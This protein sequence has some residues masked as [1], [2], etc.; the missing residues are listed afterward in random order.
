MLEMSV[1]LPSVGVLKLRTTG[2]SESVFCAGFTGF[3]TEITEAN[4]SKQEPTFIQRYN[5]VVIPVLES[6][7]Y[8][9]HT[10]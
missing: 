10:V 4:W 2:V 9:C 5:I 7:N 6:A 8:R 3:R 1:D